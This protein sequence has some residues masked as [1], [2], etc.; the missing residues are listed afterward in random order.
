MLLTHV[1]ELETRSKNA[2]SVSAFLTPGEQAE[3]CK[4]VREPRRMFFWGGFSG[5]ER[6]A[7]V[8]LPDWIDGDIPAGDH[9]SP[10]R[11]SYI[12]SLIFGDDESGYAPLGEIAEK[13]VLCRVRGS[14]HKELHHRDILGALMNLGITRKSAGDVCMVSASEAVFAISGNLTEFVCENL[15][16]AGADS[17]AVS[18]M[19]DP[20]SFAPERSFEDLSV[21]VASMRLDCVVSALTGMSRTRTSE[22]VAAECVL[23]HGVPVKDPAA[24]LSENDVITVRGYGKYALSGTDGRTRKGRIRLN[25]KKYN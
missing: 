23:V 12:K 24:K 13:I 5:A 8:F 22:A 4:A 6:R 9:H 18:V 16:R 15:T 1:A 19:D 25:A 14:G 21:T 2:P 20:A 7:A 11:E 3:L 10:E 17:V